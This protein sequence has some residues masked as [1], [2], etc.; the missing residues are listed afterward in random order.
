[1]EATINVL[2]FGASGATGHHVVTQALAAGHSV[3]AFVRRPERF[4]LNH[5]ALRIV[6]GDVGD[7][8]AVALAMPGHDAVISTLGSSSPMTGDPVVIAGIQ[9]IVQAMASSGVSR[10]IY[11]SFIGVR[12][13]RADAGPLIRYVARFPLRH[14]I[15]DH[16]AK[17]Q[18]VAASGLRWTIVRAPKLH[19]GAL[20][21][22]Y[23]TGGTIA[24][25]RFFPQLSRAD[26]AHFLVRQLTERDYENR[27]VRMLP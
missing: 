7:A 20:T 21:A 10:F 15:A 17:E 13:S 16:E 4:G 9:H 3:T 1:V 26:V 23:R 19:N 24:S 27:V 22:S 14:E 8:N 12:D 5:P 6:Q 11:Q 18:H 2:V 25:D